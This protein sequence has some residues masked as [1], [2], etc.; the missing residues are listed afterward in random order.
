MERL[1]IAPAS[2]VTSLLTCSRCT[3]GDRHWD[4]IAGKPY[5]PN[6]Q[7]ALIQ[8]EAPPLVERPEKHRCVVCNRQGT[9]RFLTYPLHAD[10]PVEM[11][12]CAEHLRSLLGRKL[13]PYAF[14]QLRRQLQALNFKSDE[15][16]LL[17]GEFYD[18]NGRALRP[19]EDAGY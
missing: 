12:L 2:S 4:Q 8:G 19:A 6:C 11:D 16:F 13:T 14:Q 5:C 18:R 10:H 17:H 15:V 1:R 7:E 3:A 9:L